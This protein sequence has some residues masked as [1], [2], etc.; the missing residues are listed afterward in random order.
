MRRLWVRFPLW[1]AP[2][3]LG[4]CQYDVTGG[5]RSHGFPALS[6]VWQHVKLSDVSLG[7]RPRYSLDAYEDVKKPTKQTEILS[8]SLF[9]HLSTFISLYLC[10]YYLSISFYLSIFLYL[11]IY[12]YIY[13]YISMTF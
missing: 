13:N 2:Y 3:W 7:T 11:F 5:D 9:L 4:Q 8:L 12:I 6:R 10:I 1:P